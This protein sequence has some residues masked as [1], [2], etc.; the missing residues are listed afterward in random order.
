MY[1]PPHLTAGCCVPTR[2]GTRWWATAKASISLQ[3]FFPG[4]TH[5]CMYATYTC[6]YAYIHT[7]MYATY[8]CTYAYIHK[9]AKNQVEFSKGLNVIVLWSSPESKLFGKVMLPRRA[10][11]R[12]FLKLT[13]P[14]FRPFFLVTALTPRDYA[15]SLE[16]ADGR[17]RIVAP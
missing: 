9:D 1:P 16:N 5:S 10:C 11:P 15:A 6:T 2:G 3:V 17:A 4:C 13:P 8:T 14:A 12:I 7:C